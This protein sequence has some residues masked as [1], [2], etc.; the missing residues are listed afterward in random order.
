M[1]LP[2]C[3]PALPRTA[4][5]PPATAAE[6][7]KPSPRSLHHQRRRTPR[8]GRDQQTER[9]Q[10]HLGSALRRTPNERHVT[11]RTPQICPA[12]LHSTGSDTRFDNAARAH[13]PSS[14]RLRPASSGTGAPSMHSPRSRI[15]GRDP[16]PP[17]GGG[18]HRRRSP[19]AP[20]SPRYQRRPQRR[21]PPPR[22][23]DDPHPDVSAPAHQRI[24]LGLHPHRMRRFSLTALLAPRR[25]TPARQP[26]TSVRSL[27]FS[28]N[29]A[30][31]V[32]ATVP[33]P[34]FP[35]SSFLSLPR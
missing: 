15:R 33:F 7:S 12:P 6:Q 2:C 19:P 27:P 17:S 21:T 18:R 11:E 16:H 10:D 35:A 20:P 5:P 32:S 22:R 8:R 3:A 4:S 34:F 14:R 30:P 13:T 28:S 9:T 24:L 29:L 23:G 26:P 1:C 25:Q 31:R